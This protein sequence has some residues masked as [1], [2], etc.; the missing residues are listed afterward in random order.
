MNLIIIIVLVVILVLT[1][2]LFT[3]LLALFQRHRKLVLINFAKDLNKRYK[4]TELKRLDMKQLPINISEMK[5]EI[6]FYGQAL[7][8]KYE[9]SQ[10]VISEKN[11]NVNQ[12]LENSSIK[13]FY[14]YKI[15]NL[16]SSKFV[17]LNQ[18]DLLMSKDKLYFFHP[19]EPETFVIKNIKNIT[20]FWEKNPLIKQK[21]FF[22]GLA[23]TY[24]KQNYFLL[25]Q[26][27]KEILNFLTYLNLLT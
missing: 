19:L 20:V 15:I 9:K 10:K 5:L 26:T 23:F 14:H 16:G 2:C 25:F 11:W 7:S 13:V 22:P 4:Q 18:T 3:L 12:V 6:Y 1:F 24:K 27:D 21:D 17:P 8:G